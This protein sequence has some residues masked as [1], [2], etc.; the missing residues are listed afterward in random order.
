MSAIPSIKSYTET[1]K[2]AAKAAGFKAKKPRKPKAKTERSLINYIHRY[3]AW[4]DKLK[5]AAKKGKGKLD[6]KNRLVNLKQKV[7]NL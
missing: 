7:A 5:T 1:E 4:V 2:Q 3:N 6:K